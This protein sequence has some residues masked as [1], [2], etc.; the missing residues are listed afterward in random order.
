M[1][2]LKYI[3]KSA[4]KQATSWVKKESE[5]EKDSAMPSGFG[6]ASSEPTK[7]R[8]RIPFFKKKPTLRFKFR[9]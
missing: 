4:L 3:G 9:S 2:V 8:N 6:S 7:T 5:A 1:P